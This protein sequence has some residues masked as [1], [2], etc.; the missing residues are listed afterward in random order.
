MIEEHGPAAT[1]P[2]NARDV[3]RWGRYQLTAS[4]T[5]AWWSASQCSLISTAD[6]HCSKDADG[7]AQASGRAN[8]GYCKAVEIL[9]V[10]TDSPQRIAPYF[11][12][13]PA[14]IPVISRLPSAILKLV[15]DEVIAD[16][17]SGAQ[18]GLG[19]GA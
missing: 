3:S 9:R 18:A 14:A 16:A 19:S 8:S 7:A 13:Q 2:M 12:A 6:I 5:C 17:R 15:L 4:G 11:E 1:R 10:V